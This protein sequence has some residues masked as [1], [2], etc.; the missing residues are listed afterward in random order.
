MAGHNRPN[1][2]SVFDNQLRMLLVIGTSQESR[3]HIARSLG[4]PR[5][6]NPRILLLKA[7]C[8]VIHS[9]EVTIVHHDGADHLQRRKSL[10]STP[11][12][13]QPI[14]CPIIS[15]ET[16]AGAIRLIALNTHEPKLSVSA[17]LGVSALSAFPFSTQRARRRRV[18]ASMLERVL[19]ARTS[20]ITKSR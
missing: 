1:C 17:V 18:E 19:N 15:S 11:D 6:T 9:T 16:V 3:L 8:L 12:S 7:I 10:D 13:P 2:A 4:P 20:R 14:R 5:P